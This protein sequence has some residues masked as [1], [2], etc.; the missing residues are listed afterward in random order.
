MYKNIR[1]YTGSIGFKSYMMYCIKKYST[2][3]EVTKF[4][5]NDITLSYHLADSTNTLELKIRIIKLLPN[6]LCCDVKIRSTS[7]KILINIITP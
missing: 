6:V 2:A 4:N 1:F 5:I 3:E 7:F